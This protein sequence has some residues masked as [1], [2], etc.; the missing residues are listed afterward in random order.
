MAIY[1]FTSSQLDSGADVYTFTGAAAGTT[2]ADQ[3]PWVPVHAFA[4]EIV[5]TFQIVK[6]GTTDTATATLQG[7]LDGGTTFFPLAA[8]TGTTNVVSLTTATTAGTT[9]VVLNLQ[10]GID[11][12]YKGV[13]P[14]FVRVAF[15]GSGTVDNK[16]VLAGNI[17]VRK[18]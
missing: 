9:T 7:S 2:L 6:A 18:I 3:T 11:T 14:L 1:P 12:P 16:S 4:D 8:G 15:T 5:A 13:K 17:L 10:M